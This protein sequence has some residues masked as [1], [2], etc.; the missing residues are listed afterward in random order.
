MRFWDL[1][2]IS[3]SKQPVNK[4]KAKHPEGESISAI[5][6]TKDNEYII[7]GDTAGYMM[8]MDFKDV[9]FKDE[10]EIEIK[11]VWFVIAHKK[12]ITSIYLC[13]NFKNDVFIVSAS[14]DHNIHLH[15]LSNGVFIG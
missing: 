13:E 15:R 8:L 4:L 6:T 11:E 3:S 2:E 9:Q 7:T 5:A 10:Q 1:W 12:M 14:M